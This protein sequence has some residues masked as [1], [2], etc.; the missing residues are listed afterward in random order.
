MCVDVCPQAAALLT[1]ISLSFHS[2][3]TC[4]FGTKYPNTNS[5]IG[6]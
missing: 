4:L 3:H 1:S 2:T 6:A 5:L